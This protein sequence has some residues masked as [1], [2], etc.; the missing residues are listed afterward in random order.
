MK[1]AVITGAGSGI[2]LATAGKLAEAGMAILGVG[3]DT[4]KLAELAKAVPEDRLATLSVDLTE[5]DAP[6][7]VVATAIE[8]WGKIDVLIN[9]AGIGRPKPVHETDDATLDYV[10]SLM[11]RAPFR[12]IRETLPHM[13]PGSA[14]V[15]ISSTYAIV[16]GTNGGAY[17]AAKSGLIGLT[18]HMALQYGPRGIRSNIVAP[19]VVQTA[20]TDH[21]FENDVF[22]KMNHHMTP[23]PRLATVEDVASTIAF[24]CSPGSELINGQTI[25]VD[26]GWSSTKYLSDFGRSSKWVAADE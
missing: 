22:K 7:K 20:M 2:G 21:V 5:D 16:G 13:Q 18:T 15:N 8:R 23:Y 25:V 4:A 17:S 19:G 24:L 14:I 26:G 9:N 11:L 3:R 6:A 12:L 10:L 1:V